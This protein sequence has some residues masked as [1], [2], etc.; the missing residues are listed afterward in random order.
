MHSPPHVSIILV[1]W[2]GRQV[3]LDCLASLQKL[4]Y[5]RYSVIVVDNASSDGSVAAIRSAF[6]HTDVLP[7]ECNLRFAGGTNAGMRHA[8]DRGTDALLLL[9][10]D[11]TVAPDFLDHMVGRM[12]S[13]SS[14]GMVAP[15]IYYHDE[16]RRIWF[17]GGE[18]SFW[19]GTMRHTGIREADIGQ[20]DTPRDI[21]YASGCCVLIRR[22]VIEQIGMLDESYF[23]YGEDADWSMRVRRAGYRLVYEPRAQVWHKLSVSAGGH[24]SAFKLMNKFRSNLR[25]FGRYA[26]WY[27]WFVFPWLNVLVNLSAAARYFLSS[28]R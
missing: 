14:I 18:I 25:F 2:N 4:M 5:T 23:M 6:P 17:A 27:Q 15:K 1:N 26:A 12:M 28:R 21:A 3:T 13:D 10:N 19:A 16:P 20:F 22:E 24:L 9:N 8:L 7:M 11:T